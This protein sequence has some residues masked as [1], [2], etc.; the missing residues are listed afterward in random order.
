MNLR[1]I[2]IAAVLASAACAHAQPKTPD[3]VSYEERRDSEAGEQIIEGYP[4]LAQAAQ[5]HYAAALSAHEDGDA[6]LAAHHTKMANM[7]WGTA[8]ARHEAQESALVQQ[9]AE[10]KRK[11]TLDALASL[12]TQLQV[13]RDA[14]SRL[15]RIATL[16][17][18]EG[19]FKARDDL[20]SAMLAIKEA[21]TVNAR[22]YAT[23][24]MNEADELVDAAA[25]ALEAGDNAAVSKKSAAAKKKAL[26]AKSAAAPE[27]T[28]NGRQIELDRKRR[29]L[30]ADA[31]DIRG[32]SASMTEGGV[33]ITLHKLFGSGDATVDTDKHGELDALA[34]LASK[35]EGYTLVIEGHTDN[36]GGSNRNISLSQARADA[37]VAHL[38]RKGVSPARMTATGRGAASPVANNKTKTGRAENRR[39]EIIFVEPRS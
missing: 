37:V 1:T 8:T 32:G 6:E 35:Y 33:T 30:F 22:E 23:S 28:K 16:E 21:E 17:A 10:S 19:S 27:Y 12:N 15:D 25:V 39:I 4:D 5:Q 13:E 11:E 20:A 26:Q 2:A 36:R 34:D 3:M 31:G 7:S 38:S 18:K 29:K 14:V 9:Q 24:L